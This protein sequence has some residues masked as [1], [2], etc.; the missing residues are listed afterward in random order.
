[1]QRIVFLIIF[2]ITGVGA[3]SA[4][5]TQTYKYDALGRLTANTTSN[6]GGGGAW[7]LYQFDNAGNRSS[8]RSSII[9]APSSRH[10][11]LAYEQIVTG[12]ALYSPNFVYE[13]VVQSDGNLVLRTSSS[14]L[15][16]AGTSTG[17][18][19]TAYMGGG[20]QLS[21]YNSDLNPLWQSAS[22][23]SAASKL[24]VGDDGSLRIYD[25]PTPIW[26]AA[27]GCP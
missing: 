27:G 11:L 19:I 4:Q 12:Q 7:N 1:M 6:Y 26:T 3:A 5:T 18:T 14:V 24:V 10:E 25:G 22:S 8:V 23:G 9:N 17:A 20:G 16:C 15:W 21:L 13:L 2:L